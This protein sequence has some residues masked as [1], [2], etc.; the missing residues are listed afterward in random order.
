MTYVASVIRWP[1]NY[2]G[3]GSSWDLI[4]VELDDD[5]AGPCA[6]RSAPLCLPRPSSS[7]SQHFIYRILQSSSFQEE[8]SSHA[9]ASESGIVSARGTNER[10]L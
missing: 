10:L 9:D 8:Y 4:V 5:Q 1:M 6:N 2:E 3:T 7:S